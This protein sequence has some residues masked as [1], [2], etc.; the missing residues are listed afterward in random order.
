MIFVSVHKKVGYLAVGILALAVIASTTY[1]E[2]AFIWDLKGTGLDKDRAYAV[3]QN[4]ETGKQQWVGVGEMI[5]EARVVRIERARVVIVDQNV[6][7]IDLALAGLESDHITP[8]LS[9]PKDRVEMGKDLNGFLNDEVYH[10]LERP[11]P[12]TENERKKLVA[13]LMRAFKEGKLAPDSTTL[14]I[15]GGEE[16]IKGAKTATEIKSMG[17]QKED[18]LL[19]MNGISPDSDKKWQDIFDVIKRARLVTFSYLHG[20]ELDSKAFEVQ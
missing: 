2:Q 3:L 20:D 7:R 12:M 18:L 19:Q 14:V 6:G 13:E 11:V 8:L 9:S 10:L 1:G 5:G 15:G 17:L 4:K 16:W